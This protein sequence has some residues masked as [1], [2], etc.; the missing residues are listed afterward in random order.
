MISL[1]EMSKIS[2]AAGGEGTDYDFVTYIAKDKRDNR[3]ML[4]HTPPSNVLSLSPDCHVFD[5]GLLS[6]DVLATIGQSFTIMTEVRMHA[7]MGGWVQPLSAQWRCTS[8]LVSHR[9]HAS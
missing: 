6:D 7:C 5:C 3:C 2:Y 4:D 9:A 8:A 1:D